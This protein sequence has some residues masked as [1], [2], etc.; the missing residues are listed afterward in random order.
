[1]KTLS[2]TVAR[3]SI[4]VVLSGCSQYTQ[5][6][7]DRHAEREAREHAERAAHE[8]EMAKREEEFHREIA[9]YKMM[10]APAT[11]YD[12]FDI[13]QRISEKDLVLGLL[14]F[15]RI[16]KIRNELARRNQSLMPIDT[17]SIDSTL[18]DVPSIYLTKAIQYDRYVE[19]TSDTSYYNAIHDV[20]KEP[21]E[22]EGD[23]AIIAKT[24]SVV[25]IVP[26]RFIKTNIP[27]KYFVN[28]KAFGPS[29]GLCDTEKYYSQ[30]KC[31]RQTGSGFVI[32]P[33]HVV[34][35]FHCVRDYT[36]SSV[37]VI[38]DV[39]LTGNSDRKE[40]PAS[41]MFR[42]KVTAINGGYNERTNIYPGG[43]F[44]ILET[45]KDMPED[46]I[47]PLV[48]P[49]TIPTEPLYTLGYPDGLTLKILSDG[50]IID[51]K[52]SLQYH[53]EMHS[54]KGCSGAPVF[55]A[56]THNV[57]GIQL[58]RDA[59]GPDYV[60]LPGSSCKTTRR[61]KPGECEGMDLLKIEVVL[62]ALKRASPAITTTNPGR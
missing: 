49:D 20:R 32:S 51:E 8:E 55:S 56:L 3:I 36:A 2:E 58:G 15:Y 45:F 7:Y 24:K 50:R 52:D 44:A 1:M 6:A 60:Q 39:D 40:I 9:N 47:L 10:E 35:A 27:G 48:A 42:A 31:V 53:S 61:C 14:N 30:Q 16:D 17:P 18:F 23:S 43:D 62:K 29:M 19:K 54:M 46:R 28:V 34:T 21:W 12:S 33:R 38:F 13:E 5:P 11:I 57:I 25:M 59:T 22:R 26:W 4:L 41:K 37:A